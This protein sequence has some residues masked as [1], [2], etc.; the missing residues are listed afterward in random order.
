MGAL[1][2]ICFGR[3]MG[4]TIVKTNPRGEYIIEW[5]RK[6]IGEVHGMDRSNVSIQCLWTS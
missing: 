1:I 4:D 2:Q 6:Y 3:R 5:Y